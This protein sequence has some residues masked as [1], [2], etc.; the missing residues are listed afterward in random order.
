ME[1]KVGLL[2]AW[3]E[4]IDEEFIEIIQK[5]DIAYGGLLQS[6]PQTMSAIRWIE[7]AIAEKECI[8]TGAN[9]IADLDKCTTG[10]L[11]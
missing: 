10:C 9:T 6:P 1:W 3:I 11:L 7:D 2:E 8:Q 4:D 5:I